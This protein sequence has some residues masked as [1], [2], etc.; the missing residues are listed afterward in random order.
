MS[1]D[2]FREKI[3]FSCNVATAVSGVLGFLLL[4]MAYE[5]YNLGRPIDLTVKLAIVC[6]VIMVISFFIGR[7]YKEEDSLTLKDWIEV[8]VI[9]IFPQPSD[10]SIEQFG[11][12]A[13]QSAL[14]KKMGRGISVKNLLLFIFLTGL[15]V[16]MGFS[17]Y[18]IWYYKDGRQGILSW[19][20]PLT[21]KMPLFFHIVI[22][23]MLLAYVIAIGMRIRKDANPILEYISEKN[24][25]FYEVNQD[26]LDSV[27]C[28]GSLWVGKRYLFARE[29]SSCRMI[30]IEEI[31]SVTYNRAFGKIY[32][33]LTI[34]AKEETVIQYHID[35]G[36]YN[37]LQEELKRNIDV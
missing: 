24:L 22:C 29:M 8:L 23:I 4:F 13:S 11:A 34:E 2:D 15:T 9:L 25:N 32:Y 19:D 5:D 10:H 30:P 36:P 16:L 6:L 21:Y 26:F 33:L 12:D 17:A 37:R 3:K 7:I 20:D 14:W 18:Y 31:E 27:Y 35:V 1:D 28:G